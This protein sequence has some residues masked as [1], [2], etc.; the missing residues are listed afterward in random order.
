M[1]QEEIRAHLDRIV[2]SDTGEHMAAETR[3]A[4]S[5]VHRRRKASVNDFLDSCARLF[6]GGK[7]GSVGGDP[8]NGY[9]F[10]PRRE[11]EPMPDPADTEAV[12]DM[13]AAS[14]VPEPAIF[15]RYRKNAEGNARRNARERYETEQMDRINAEIARNSPDFVDGAAWAFQ[16]E[17]PL[18]GP[19][20]DDAQIYDPDC[21]VG[22]FRD[23]FEG[24][25]DYTELCR[26]ET[27]KVLSIEASAERWA[28]YE[29]AVRQT[30]RMADMCEA[31]GLRVRYAAP[32][33]PNIEGRPV[34]PRVALVPA[35]EPDKVIYMP[36]VARLAVFPVF[37]RALRAEKIRSL[38]YIM[39]FLRYPR[40]ATFTSGSRD[41][42]EAFLSNLRSEHMSF[43]H[44][45]G[46]L[47]KHRIFRRHIDAVFVGPE[48]GTPKEASPDGIRADLSFHHHVHVLY[49][50]RKRRDGRM[51]SKDQWARLRKW[52]RLKLA[53]LRR[54]WTEKDRPRGLRD[55]DGIHCE[56][57]RRVENVNE[58]CKYPFKDADIEKVMEF[59]GPLAVRTFVEQTKG[60]RYATPLGQLRKKRRE[61]KMAGKRFVIE[62]THDGPVVT[63]RRNWN[64]ARWDTWGARERRLW[65][66]KLRRAMKPEACAKHQK[67]MEA[68]VIEKTRAMLWRLCELSEEIKR[69]KKHIDAGE[70]VSK[71]EEKQKDAE[72]QKRFLWKWLRDLFETFP[73]TQAKSGLSDQLAAP[74]LEGLRDYFAESRFRCEFEAIWEQGLSEQEERE[75][76]RKIEENDPQKR[77]EKPPL[78][79][80]LMGRCAPHANGYWRV[81]QPVFAVVGYDGDFEAMKR[82]SPEV[83]RV[84]EQACEHI[85][86]ALRVADRVAAVPRHGACVR[87][88]ERAPAVRPDGGIILPG[89]HY[90]NNSPGSAPPWT[91]DPDFWPP[92]WAETPEEN[93]TS[94]LQTA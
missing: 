68:K 55:E 23:Y 9:T 89:T 1:T 10:M 43:R 19:G 90:P 66:A 35:G 51:W 56:L 61:V 4:Y 60:L 64:L 77:P 32:G 3:D 13:A 86:A 45:V 38:R 71:W 92:E 91:P 11:P 36:N 14:L 2:A 83:R 59:G 62:S 54:G 17:L 8:I 93:A 53:A 42:E 87:G 81:S 12:F 27:G 37:S 26:N 82:R 44:D 30:E 76:R 58:V 70:S 28:S 50:A 74:W 34:R 21:A 72:G 75:K 57:G 22:E 79:N 18:A 6:T 80:H 47:M 65:R 20:L 63:I 52:C 31:A 29:L 84:C 16:P 46:E 67:K 25:A 15:R 73:K 69:A 48:Y 78:K 24:E 88:R 7:K 39:Q 5:P 41:R 33:E 85:A 49:E 40:M 94:P